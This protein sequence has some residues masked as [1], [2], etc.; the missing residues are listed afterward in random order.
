MCGA[1]SPPSP[2]AFDQAEGNLRGFRDS[3]R[4][5]ETPTLSDMPS[6]EGAVTERDYYDIVE[7]LRTLR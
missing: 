2:T 3:G 5:V 1:G 7:F 6:Y 4:A